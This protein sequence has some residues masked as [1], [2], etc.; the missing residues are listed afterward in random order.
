L[1]F[2]ILEKQLANISDRGFLFLRSTLLLSVLRLA[3]VAHQTMVPANS[4]YL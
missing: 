1:G 2:F 4:L 3:N